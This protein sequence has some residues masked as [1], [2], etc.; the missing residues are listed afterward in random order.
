MQSPHPNAP[1]RLTL[2]GLSGRVSVSPAYHH[3]VPVASYTVEPAPGPAGPR[4]QDQ[5]EGWQREAMKAARRDA[6]KR[7]MLG[8]AGSGDMPAFTSDGSG[9]ADDPFQRT[10][11]GEMLAVFQAIDV[12]QSNFITKQNFRDFMAS[13]GE[14]V[15]EDELDDAFREADVTGDSRVHYEEFERIIRLREAQDQHLWELFKVMD[16]HN[17][18]FVEGEE[19]AEFM[20]ASGEDVDM[21]AVVEML[22]EADLAGDGR[23]SFQEFK[24]IMRWQLI[25]QV[26]PNRLRPQGRGQRGQRATCNVVLLSV[27]RLVA[28]AAA[29]VAACLA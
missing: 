11:S 21:E 3:Q 20:H 19:L 5:A 12:D 17:T 28:A 27:L 26:R 22:E 18:G 24:Y 8:E 7:G 25:E 29:A 9:A 14:E 16:L 2:S 13:V 4:G 10:S 1:Q 15:T 6:M 23:V